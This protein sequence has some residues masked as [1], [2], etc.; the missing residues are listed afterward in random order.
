MRNYSIRYV[1]RI[2]VWAY[3]EIEAENLDAALDSL[4][5][6]PDRFTVEVDLD[7]VD[8]APG[9]DDSEFEMAEVLSDEKEWT[10]IAYFKEETKP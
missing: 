9:F 10:D 8:E 6:D 1:K 5:A 4:A 7:S 3:A 2:P